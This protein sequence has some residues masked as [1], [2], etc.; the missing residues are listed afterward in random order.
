MLPTAA[1]AE[2]SK[3][4]T[5]NTPGTPTALTDPANTRAGYLE[6]DANLA[7]AAYGYISKGF[8]KPSGYTD[9]GK[10]TYNDNQRMYVLLKPGETVYY[11]VHRIPHTLN[12]SGTT[13]A[14]QLVQNNLIISA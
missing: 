1:L 5:P 9:N 4:L 6:H 2:G 10:F 7:G 8:L 3:Q 11:G 14:S 13:T 12:P